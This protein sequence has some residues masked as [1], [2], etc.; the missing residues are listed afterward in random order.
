[1]SIFPQ[2]I[3]DR[4]HPEAEEVTIVGNHVEENL[5]NSKNVSDELLQAF[6]LEVLTTFGEPIDLEKLQQFS[7]Q[8]ADGKAYTEHKFMAVFSGGQA[9]CHQTNVP[10]INPHDDYCVN[11][12]TLS[13]K[14]IPKFYDL[15]VHNHTW[16]E[17]LAGSIT[18]DHW[19]VGVSEKPNIKDV[20]FLHPN[21]RAVASHFGMPTPHLEEISWFTDNTTFRKVFGLTYNTETLEPIKLKMYYYPGD[22]NMEFTVFDEVHDAKSS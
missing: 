8:A 7:F 9:D 3:N 21:A 1:M 5:F 4:I 12:F 2:H 10:V 18:I 17:L 15:D 22:P 11:Y 13:L 14:R 20:Y 19:G 16:P 6:R